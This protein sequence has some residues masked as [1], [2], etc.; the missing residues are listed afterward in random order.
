[1]PRCFNALCVCALFFLC[2]IFVFFY[3]Y[4]FVVSVVFPFSHDASEAYL[5]DDFDEFDDPFGDIPFSKLPLNLSPCE[6]VQIESNFL[7]LKQY[8]LLRFMYLCVS[9]RVL[10]K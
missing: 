8:I 9:V 2:I 6:Y 5:D 4:L 7:V 3:I 10:V 1:M